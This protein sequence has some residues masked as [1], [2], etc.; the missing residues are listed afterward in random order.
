MRYFTWSPDGSTILALVEDYG[1]PD[2][3]YEMVSF[4]ATGQEQDRKNIGLSFAY[5]DLSDKLDFSSDRKS[6]FMQSKDDIY[7]INIDNGKQRLLI[8]NEDFVTASPSGNIFLT[9]TTPKASSRDSQEYAIYSLEGGIL[10]KIISRKLPPESFYFAYDTF[11]R[12]KFISDSIFAVD[13]GSGPSSLT[14]FDTL[15]QVQY[16]TNDGKYVSLFSFADKTSQLLYIA[17]SSFYR[18]DIANKLVQE[19]SRAPKQTYSLDVSPTSELIVYTVDDLKRG[20]FY[21]YYDPSSII[22]YNL[23][24]REEKKLASNAS[25]TARI[26]PDGKYV[27]YFTSENRDIHLHIVPVP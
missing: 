3:A 25:S 9:H 26:S 1:M 27:A 17:D 24:T 22:E 20:W 10:R 12:P 7:L 5:F 16:S 21:T 23:K 14:F 4:N 11:G 15:L 19:V 2:F 18:Y 6:F 13:Y 8:P